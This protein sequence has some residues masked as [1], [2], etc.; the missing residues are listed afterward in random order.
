MGEA[1][2]DAL[3]VGFDSKLRMEFHRVKVTSDAG[4]LAFPLPGHGRVRDK[5]GGGPTDHDRPVPGRG[6]VK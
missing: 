1:K 6:P 4:L 2:N 3:E 5:Y